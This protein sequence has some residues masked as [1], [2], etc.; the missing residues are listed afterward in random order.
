MAEVP[1]VAS[2]VRHLPRLAVLVLTSLLAATAVAGA[3]ARSDGSV[4]A[5]AQ[6]ARLATQVPDRTLNRVGAGGIPGPT[7]TKL[8]GARL[9]SGGKPELLVTSVAWCCQRVRSNSL[10]TMN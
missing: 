5:P 7:V 4:P 9:R 2:I 1:A 3:T 8:H 10:Q 6:I